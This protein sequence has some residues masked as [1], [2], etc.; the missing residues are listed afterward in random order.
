MYKP[1]K[2]D[3]ELLIRARDYCISIA[4]NIKDEYYTP[5]NASR[6]NCAS[7]IIDDAINSLSDQLKALTP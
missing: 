2:E 1:N 6:L 3:I 7:S 5:I 4:D